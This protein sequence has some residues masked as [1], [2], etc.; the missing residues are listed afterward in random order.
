MRIGVHILPAKAPQADPEAAMKQPASN[1]QPNPRN[2]RR[3]RARWGCR[4]QG[5]PLNKLLSSDIEMVISEYF[6]FVPDSHISRRSHTLAMSQLHMFLWRELMSLSP[7][8]VATAFGKSYTT[9]LRACKAVQT[10]IRSK[11]AFRD[12]VWEIVRELGYDPDTF[13]NLRQR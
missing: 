13:Q 6:P 12:T 8:E 1:R 10:R 4:T 5:Q 11:K 2:I 7:S 9:V 3:V